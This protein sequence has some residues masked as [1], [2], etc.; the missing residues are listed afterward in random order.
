MIVF[1]LK[2]HNDHCFE[3]WFEDS[4]AFEEQMEQGLVECPVCG[5]DSVTKVLSPIA[6]GSSTTGP[7]PAKEPGAEA[8]ALLMKMAEFVDKN[9]DN[10]G[11]G[12]TKEAL[13]MHYGVTEPRNIRGTSTK[14]EEDLL[15]EEGVAFHKLPLP[16]PEDPD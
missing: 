1:D 5:D 3:G 11:S 10:V 15:A 13:K 8:Q 9:F 2:C 6:I 16:L 7:G 12:F 4:Q 14:E